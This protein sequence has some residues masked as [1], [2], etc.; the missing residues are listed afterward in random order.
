MGWRGIRLVPLAVAI[1]GLLIPLVA[2]GGYLWP[3]TLIWALLVAV[4]AIAEFVY[5]SAR[6]PRI[7][8]TAVALPFLFL[9]AFEG[10]WWLI[11]ADLAQLVIEIRSPETQRGREQGSGPG[12]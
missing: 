12:A 6:E 7:V 10:G 3:V 2:S 5:P 8:V 4:F 1:M 11:P 9:A